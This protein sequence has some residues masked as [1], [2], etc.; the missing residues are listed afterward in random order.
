MFRYFYFKL[1]LFLFVDVS[2]G[3]RILSPVL[4]LRRV[5]LH[6]MLLWWFYFLFP[7]SFGVLP[8]LYLHKISYTSCRFYYNS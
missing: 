6:V 4:L 2:W 8:F 1:E 3:L 7:D 5:E